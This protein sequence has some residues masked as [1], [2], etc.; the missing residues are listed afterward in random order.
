MKLRGTAG[1][2]SPNKLVNADAQG[3][4]RTRFASCAPA[5]GRGL[6]A[7]Y[8]AWEQFTESAH[9]Q[10]SASVRELGSL[11]GQDLTRRGAFSII[12]ARVRC[13]ARVTSLATAGRLRR[14]CFGPGSC[15]S[16]ICSLRA[17]TPPVPVMHLL[18]STT[19]AHNTPVNAD[20]QGRPRTRFASCAP[21]RG[22]RL[23]AR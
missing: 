13:G 18:L 22:R 17:T 5:R 23:L 12:G 7:R 14:E 15:H 10:P 16:T 4:P 6:H 1:A 9:P 8:V 20:A 2:P 3:R 19:A 11:A 21:F